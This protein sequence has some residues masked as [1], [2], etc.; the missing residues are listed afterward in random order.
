MATELLET[1]S[2]L[3]AHEEVVHSNEGIL[4]MEGHALLHELRGNVHW[5]IEF[6]RKEIALMERLHEIMR[7]EDS[8]SRAFAIQDRDEAALLERKMI[9]ERLLRAVREAEPGG[10]S[11]SS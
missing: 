2:L 6:R 11:P 1:L 9:L 7:G 10:S 5:A 4:K 8:S 3:L